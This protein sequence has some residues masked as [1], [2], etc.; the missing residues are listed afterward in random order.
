MRFCWVLK[1]S[2]EWWVY[3]SSGI[4]RG[5]FGFQIMQHASV[6]MELIGVLVDFMR[7]FRFHMIYNIVILVSNNGL[8]GIPTDPWDV[9]GLD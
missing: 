8:C 5:L 6:F 2:S 9:N 1:G 3:E 4:Y 7:D